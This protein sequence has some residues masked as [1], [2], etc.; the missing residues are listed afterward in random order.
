LSILSKSI[1]LPRL[2][3]WRFTKNHL[4]LKIWRQKVTHLCERN[5][6]AWHKSRN[7][8]IKWCLHTTFLYL[9]KKCKP[10]PDWFFCSCTRCLCS[11]MIN[12]R[13]FIAAS[14]FQS[15]SIG[16]S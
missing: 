11:Y 6:M 1:R 13:L 10:F 7:G 9:I 14:F 8:N 15:A 2:S 4:H 12:S 3:K 5:R 16:F